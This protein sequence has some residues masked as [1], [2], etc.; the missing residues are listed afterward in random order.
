M[1]PVAFIHL[2]AAV[3][4]IV[5]AIPLLRGRVPRNAWY[6]FRG[7][8]AFASEQAWREINRRGG[9]LLLGWGMVLGL[10]ALVGL[11]VGRS[12]WEIYN[13]TALAVILPGLAVMIVR[14]NRYI[15]QRPSSSDKSE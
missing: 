7:P 14:I 15:R 9:R 8:A 5:L 11:A 12:G 1:N 6:G 10:T 3:V 13:W 4:A 2:A